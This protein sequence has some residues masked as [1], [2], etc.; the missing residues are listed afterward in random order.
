[1]HGSQ[2]PTLVPTDASQLQ[3]LE[4]VN[5]W[6][7]TDIAN[8]AYKAGFASTQQAYEAAYR[9]FFIALDR[10]E[11][12]LSRQ[13]YV[14]HALARAFKH[15]LKMCSCFACLLHSPRPSRADPFKANICP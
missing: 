4:E 3:Q 10:V 11:L 13:K 5:S 9:A 12:I 8:G 1:M 6:V 7:Y 15:S 2:A 14:H